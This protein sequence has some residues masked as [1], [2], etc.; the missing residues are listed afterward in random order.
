MAFMRY[1]QVEQ[2]RVA[3]PILASLACT[4]AILASACVLVPRAFAMA[5]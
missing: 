1:A 3:L 5:P 2:R 4:A